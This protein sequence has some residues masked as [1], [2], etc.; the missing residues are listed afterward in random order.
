MRQKIRLMHQSS[1]LHHLLQLMHH[2]YPKRLHLP[3]LFGQPYRFSAHMY[4]LI[5]IYY[6]DTTPKTEGRGSK[7]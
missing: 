5:H 7:N 2:F 4:A 3:A 1:I 6:M